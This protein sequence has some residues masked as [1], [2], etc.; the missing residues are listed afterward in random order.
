MCACAHLN[1]TGQNRPSRLAICLCY[2]LQIPVCQFSF[3]LCHPLSPRPRTSTSIQRVYDLD[4]SFPDSSHK[5]LHDNQYIDKLLGVPDQEPSQLVDHPNEVRRVSPC[6]SSPPIRHFRRSLFTLI[7]LVD[8]QRNV[9]KY[10]V[11]YVVLKGSFLRPTNCLNTFHPLPGHR[12]RMS[13]F[14]MYTREPPMTPSGA[15]PT[16]RLAPSNGLRPRS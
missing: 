9:S 6:Q 11:R 10:C 3:Y 16:P 15:P 7:L 2:S 8:Y 12:K 4:K 5:L 13:G 1:A 14:V